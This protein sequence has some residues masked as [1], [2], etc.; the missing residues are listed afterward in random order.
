[1]LRTERKPSS[2]SLSLSLSQWY[3]FKRRQI[4]GEMLSPVP[5]GPLLDPSHG[6]EVVGVLHVFS[7]MLPGVTKG[8]GMTFMNIPNASLIV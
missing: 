1:M 6:L 7:K 4:H 2:L 5:P 8:Q 3:L